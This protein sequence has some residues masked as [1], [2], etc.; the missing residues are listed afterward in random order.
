[1]NAMRKTRAFTLVEMMAVVV[2]IGILAAVIAPKFFDQVNEAQI[3]RARQDIEALKKAAT[4]FKF[5]TNKFPE[6]LRDLVREPD[7]ARG[8]KGPYIERLPRDPWD[9]EYQFRSPGNDGREFDIWSLGQD[10]KEGGEG[11]DA[12]IT[13]WVE[14]E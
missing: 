6:E 1:M 4:F 3:V 11:M 8:W 2:I 7:N 14:D 5:H 13:S 10:E 9:N 12:D